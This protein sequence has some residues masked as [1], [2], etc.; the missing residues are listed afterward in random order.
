MSARDK[1]DKPA[2]RFEATFI[3][4][5]PTQAQAGA[6]RE[7]TE[8][9]I[10]PQIFYVRMW[11]ET[12]S[13]LVADSVIRG[14]EGALLAAIA[15]LGGIVYRTGTTFFGFPGLDGLHA[16]KAAREA[17]DRCALAAGPS[18]I[19]GLSCS[20]VGSRRFADVLTKPWEFIGSSRLNEALTSR[21][22]FHQMVVL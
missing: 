15:R 14:P 17:R 8:F 22:R 1:S 3:P 11:N 7:S 6:P 13:E 2:G 4:S 18:V 12:G 20:T 9:A 21:V 19:V 10:V 5:R 16:L